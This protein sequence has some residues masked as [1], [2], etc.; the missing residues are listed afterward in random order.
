MR[1]PIKREGVEVILRLAE[2]G[3]WLQWILDPPFDWKNKNKKKQEYALTKK[4]TTEHIYIDLT[5]RGQ[6]LV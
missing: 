2:G 6:W 1:I 5:L 3:I 4:I